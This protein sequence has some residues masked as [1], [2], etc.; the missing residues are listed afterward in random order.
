MKQ[1][2]VCLALLVIQTV[3]H[4]KVDVLN[5]DQV[6]ISRIKGFKKDIMT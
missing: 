3:I 4:D 1:L 6:S 2:Y 5:L